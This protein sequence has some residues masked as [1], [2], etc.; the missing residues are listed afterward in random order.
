MTDIDVNN[1]QMDVVTYMS[2]GAISEIG[3]H[4]TLS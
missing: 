2:T 4:V 3:R 1:T